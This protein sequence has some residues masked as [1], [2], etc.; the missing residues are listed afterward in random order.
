MINNANSIIF[1]A[2]SRISRISSTH[3]EEDSIHIHELVVGKCG[4][5]TMR[6]ELSALPETSN[7]D[8][9]LNVIVVGGNSC[10]FSIFRAG[11][12]KR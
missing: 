12:E 3:H 10:A 7:E 9:G 2:N 11:C 5:V 4:T 1:E 6:I 8:V